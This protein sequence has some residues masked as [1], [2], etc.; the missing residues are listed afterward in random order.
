[1]NRQRVFAAE[2]YIQI[3]LSLSIPQTTGAGMLVVQTL[4]QLFQPVRRLIMFTE[5]YRYWQ[6]HTL[7]SLARLFCPL[8]PLRTSPT[9]GQQPRFGASHRYTVNSG[10]GSIGTA[11]TVG[12][13]SIPTAITTATH[14]N[15]QFQTSLQQ[16]SH[17]IQP[18]PLSARSRSN[19][20][21]NGLINNTIVTSNTNIVLLPPAALTLVQHL[22]THNNPM[23]N[24][25]GDDRRHDSISVRHDVEKEESTGTGSPIR[26][27]RQ[28]HVDTGA[29]PISKVR[30]FDD[31]NNNYGGGDPT[32]T[33]VATAPTAFVHDGK[34]T[35]TIGT[36][37][38]HV[39]STIGQNGSGVGVG[40]GTLVVSSTM[41]DTKI[42]SIP[43]A[44]RPASLF[45]LNVLIVSLLA[46]TCGL[47]GYLLIFICQFQYGSNR[48]HFPRTSDTQTIRV[49]QWTLIALLLQCTFCVFVHFYMLRTYNVYVFAHT[50][51]ECRPY[52]WHYMLIT[53]LA[54]Y[55]LYG[56]L[57]SHHAVWSDFVTGKSSYT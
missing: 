46:K 32:I 31:T 57:L 15:I 21:D 14:R 20:S 33:P 2:L 41:E 5:R 44:R 8:A 4:L 47:V 22:S 1:M 25:N 54:I 12:T 26:P 50:L 35:V 24:N 40:E 29:T 55:A 53:F 18:V 42:S 52:Y 3:F 23:N 9:L 13:S 19:V 39:T 51:E 38:S 27:R 6:L 48:A 28:L 16:P 36:L 37:S 11:T 45:R 49:I 10:N 17:P 43:F 56:M 34:G 7:R 30:R